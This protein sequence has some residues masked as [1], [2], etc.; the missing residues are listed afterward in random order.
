M[1]AHRHPCLLSMLFV[2]QQ[3]VLLQRISNL[4][5]AMLFR[6]AWIQL[7][8]SDSVPMNLVAVV[9]S[10]K[11]IEWILSSNAAVSSG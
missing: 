8:D 3:V 11:Q 4:V 1:Q 5:Q 6:G 7:H 2:I 9:D 10:I